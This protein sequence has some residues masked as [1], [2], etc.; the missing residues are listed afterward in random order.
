M[1][2]N[3]V[4][5]HYGA[6]LPVNCA[7]TME[8]SHQWGHVS[9][10]PCRSNT[11][12]VWGEKYT[13]TVQY[14]P[15]L[16]Q[17]SSSLYIHQY[18]HPPIHYHYHTPMYL[19]PDP[20]INRIHSPRKTNI[21]KSTAS[22]SQQLQ[23]YESHSWT[24]SSIDR[25]NDLA[26]QGIG[27][28]GSKHQPSNTACPGGMKLGL[29]EEERGRGWLAAVSGTEEQWAGQ[30]EANAAMQASSLSWC[31]SSACRVSSSGRLTS[32]HQLPSHVVAYIPES[33]H[34]ACSTNTLRAHESE[35]KT[36]SIHSYLTQAA[37]HRAKMAFIH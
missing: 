11:G 10:F 35:S 2:I 16:F 23:Q 33:Q 12:T 19:T 9:F 13:F 15:P 29:K 4:G 20:W 8:L 17:Y 24:A 7:I 34:D 26:G 28:R 3:R 21:D 25:S 27:G 30:I 36:L 31:A 5:L 6:T 14:T 37:H 1:V 32:E 22:S 18:I